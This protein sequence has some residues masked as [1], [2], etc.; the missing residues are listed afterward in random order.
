VTPFS[1][2]EDRLLAP[3]LAFLLL[4]GMAGLY[5]LTRLVKQALMRLRLV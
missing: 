1:P 4:A 2:L 5:H 3:S